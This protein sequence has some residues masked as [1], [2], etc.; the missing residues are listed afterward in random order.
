[1]PSRLRSQIAIVGAELASS[2]RR[3]W[4]G[5]TTVV[6]FEIRALAAKAA[7]QSAISDAFPP[8]DGRS[9]SRPSAG[10]DPGGLSQAAPDAQPPG[11]PYIKP[12]RPGPRVNLARGVCHAE[13]NDGRQSANRNA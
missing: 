11:P 3:I 7:D 2:L 1:M 9:P 5:S 8:A 13:D 12:W 6:L 10:R 4:R